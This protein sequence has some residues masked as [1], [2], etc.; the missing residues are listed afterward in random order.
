M[1]MIV[2][3]LGV[4]MFIS[5]WVLAYGTGDAWNTWLT[6]AIIVL[7]AL[8]ALSRGGVWPER[9]NLVLGAWMFI[10]PWVLAF[11]DPSAGASINQWIVGALVFIISGACMA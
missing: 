5:P 2:T 9:V 1:D 11:S 7:S 3:V 10:S 6:S 4:W 8:S